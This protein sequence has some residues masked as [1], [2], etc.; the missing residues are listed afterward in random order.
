[1][2]DES[3]LTPSGIK[4]FGREFKALTLADV[5]PKIRSGNNFLHEQLAADGARLARIYGFSY[6]GQ[7]FD[8]ASPV[9]FLVHKEG[10]APTKAAGSTGIAAKDWDFAGDILMWEYDQA[11][12]TVRIDIESGPLEDLLLAAEL[13]SGMAEVGSAGA[14]ARGA[15]ARGAHARGAHARG[16]HARGAHA[17]GAHARGA[18]ARSNRGDSD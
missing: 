9:V 7:Y 5:P 13:D 12:F 6:Q 17:R 3:L 2:S 11:D 15:H 18:H 1:M 4:L 10:V 8:L 14:H 16:A